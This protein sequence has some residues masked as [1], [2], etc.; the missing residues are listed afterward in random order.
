MKKKTLY[1]VRHAKS[2]WAD[3]SM[4]DKE[5]P[6]N[7]RGR[8][9]APIMA[10]Y[11]KTMGFVPDLIIS[12]TAVRA[13]STAEV[14]KKV[15]G[16]SDDNY[17]KYDSLYHAPASMY[18]ES[19]YELLETQQ[20][21]MLFG[22]NPGITYLANEVSDQYIDNVPTCGLLVVTSTADTWAEVDASNSTLVSMQVPKN[23][24]DEV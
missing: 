5:R 4:T 18:Y 2:S 20:S 19:C 23:L 6:L 1:I 7:G 17:R 16:V 15:L 10:E 8:R 24:S 14:F 11:C 13:Y 9:A 22:H 3:L 12:S 21:V